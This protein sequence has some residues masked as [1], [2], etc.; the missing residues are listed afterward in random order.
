MTKP[1]ILPGPSLE[2]LAKKLYEK[3][4]FNFACLPTD[5][6]WVKDRENVRE[7]YRAMAWEEL[8]RAKI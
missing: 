8:A 2:A 1:M 4:G 6:A 7:R 3:D 5:E